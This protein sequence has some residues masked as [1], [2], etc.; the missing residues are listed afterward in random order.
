MPLA[1]RKRRSSLGFL[2]QIAAVRENEDWL[3]DSVTDL[4]KGIGE[5]G[6]PDSPFAKL[7][8]RYDF[9]NFLATALPGK[10]LLDTFLLTRLQIKG[11]FLHFFDDVFLLN[12]SLET[13]QRILNRFTVLNADF[14]QLNTPPIR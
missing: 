4:R 5:S 10:F 8:F 6:N 3:A 2:N 12:L 14:G 9:S 11:V 13:P 1:K 7:F